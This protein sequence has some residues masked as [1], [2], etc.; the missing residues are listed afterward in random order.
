MN[1]DLITFLIAKLMRRDPRMVERK[2]TGLA[3]ARKRVRLFSES[4]IHCILLFFIY[5]FHT[6]LFLLATRAHDL[7]NSTPGSNVRLCYSDSLSRHP[8]FDGLVLYLLSLYTIPNAYTQYTTTPQ[9]LLYML[10]STSSAGRTGGYGR[11]DYVKS[12]K[13]CKIHAGFQVQVVVSKA[14]RTIFSLVPQ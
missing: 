3:K 9:V 12:T 14:A 4:I 6:C 2:K 5:I 13:L 7:H 8:R 11:A 10:Q 1:V